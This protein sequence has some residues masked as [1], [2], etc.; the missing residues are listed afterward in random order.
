VNGGYVY[1]SIDLETNWGECNGNTELVAVQRVT[2]DEKIEQAELTWGCAPV[3]GEP[4]LVICDCDLIVYLCFR[5]REL[6]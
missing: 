5:C 6:N 3:Q 4:L 2:T 1:A